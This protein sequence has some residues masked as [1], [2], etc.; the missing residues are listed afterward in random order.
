MT[1]GTMTTPSAAAL[2]QRLSTLVGL[3][4][5]YVV[6]EV[7]SHAVVQGRVG[8][9]SFDSAIF[10]NLSEDHLDYHGSMEEYY[11]AKKRLF[12]QAARAI[13]CTDDDYGARLCRELTIPHKRVAVIDTDADYTLGELYEAGM[14]RTQY[15]CQAPYGS[16]EVVYPLFS[17][18]NVY[19]TL[20]AIAAASEAGL[21][22]GEITRA[23][24]T[25]PQPCGRLEKLPLKKP[26]SVVIDYA[27]TPDAVQ[28]AIKTVRRATRGRLLTLLGAGGERER[29]KRPKM[30]K[31]AVTHSDTVLFTSDN[32]R[33]ESPAAIFSD[34]LSGVG[35][36]KNFLL[37]PDRADAIRHGID[38]LRE[39]DTLLLLGKGHE[40]YLIEGEEARPFSE[41]RVVYDYLKEKES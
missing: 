2:Y 23:L 31:I 19:N 22:P 9:L 18:F 10:T 25:L 35:T 20:L 5:E 14:E 8:G 7:S 34:L 11:L 3:G 15:L 24:R 21:C 36:K 33:T 39:E 29:E 27:H 28:G 37:I 6:M 26:F 13:V 32:S 16:F 40:E 12:A 41:R 38:L 17:A 4:A 1:N 30:A